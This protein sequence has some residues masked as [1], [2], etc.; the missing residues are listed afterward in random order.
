MKAIAQIE[1]DGRLLIDVQVLRDAG[2]VPGERVEI[3]SVGD[4][5]FVSR[6]RSVEN[7]FEQWRGTDRSR[8]PMSLDEIIAEQREM[9]GYDDLD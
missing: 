8:P 5:L 9:R 6:E 7:V 2:L 1:Q 4:H 3:S